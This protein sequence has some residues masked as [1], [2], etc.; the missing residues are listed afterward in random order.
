[1]LNAEYDRSLY[2]GFCD[3]DARAGIMGVLY[4]LALD[5]RFYR[6]CWTR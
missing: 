1:V 5:G 2:A 3:A 6:P 4:N